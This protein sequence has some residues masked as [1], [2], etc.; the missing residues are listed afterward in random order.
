MKKQQID[1][2]ST[3]ACGVLIIL[4][5]TMVFLAAGELQQSVSVEEKQ[6]PLQE[7]SLLYQDDNILCYHISRGVDRLG[8]WYNGS[9]ACIK[10]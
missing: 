1:W 9:Q 2:A 3:A 6:P 10:K 5:V 8:Y 7:V 4:V